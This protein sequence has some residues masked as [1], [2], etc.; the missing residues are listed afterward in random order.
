[1]KLLS[2]LILTLLLPTLLIGQINQSDTNLIKSVMNMQEI[3]WNNGNIEGFM[4]GYWNHP[5]LEFITKKGITKGWQETFKNYQKTYP[6][7]TSMGLLL[8]SCLAFVKI[9]DDNYLVNG[10]WE[11]SRKADH[12]SG[13]FTLFWKKI[14]GNWL[15]V[16]DHTS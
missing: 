8:F 2:F 11:L 9:N 6:D 12:P 7:A 1:M 4:Q 10:K 16:L 3:A 14:N 13:Y 15:I 5:N